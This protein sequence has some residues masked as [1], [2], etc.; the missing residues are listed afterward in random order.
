MAADEVVDAGEFWRYPELSAT[1]R[2][3]LSGC[4]AGALAT[5]LLRLRT[6]PPLYGHLTMDQK[7]K[8]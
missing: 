4:L 2:I 3:L 7:I 1:K 8:M 5:F 6:T